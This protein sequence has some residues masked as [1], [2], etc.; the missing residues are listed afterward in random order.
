M[1]FPRLSAYACDAL[2][3]ASMFAVQRRHRLHLESRREL[4]QYIEASESLTR[5]DFFLAPPVEEDDRANEGRW[6]WESPVRTGF[7]N[8]DQVDIELVPSREGWSAPTVF[9]LHALMS[10]SAAGYRRWAAQFNE[11]GWNACIIH[12]PFHHSRTPPGCLNGELAITADLVRTAEAV[13]QGVCELRQLMARLRRYGCREFGLCATSYGGWIGA[14]VAS[15]ERDFR[16]VAL[17]EPIMD[18]EH[19]IWKSP[20]SASVRFEL[21]RSGIDQKLIQRHFPLISPLHA[22]PTCAPER[23]LFVSGAHDTVVPPQRLRMAHEHWRG[24]KLISVRQGHFGHRMMP[25]A[26]EYLN[27]QGLV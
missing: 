16:F 2:M 8:N 7:A 21:R 9:L 20:A 24:S 13:R 6:R 18:V 25:A 14:L 15:I 3:C 23:V 5:E 22:L 10:T 12:L 4:E 17:L 27:G 11:R 1:I 19:A 26:W